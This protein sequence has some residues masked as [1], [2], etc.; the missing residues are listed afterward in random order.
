MDWLSSCSMTYLAKFVGEYCV[1]D[2]RGVFELGF[3]FI[4][5]SL[6]SVGR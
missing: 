2:L 3:V 6:F 1:G 4:G 5:G